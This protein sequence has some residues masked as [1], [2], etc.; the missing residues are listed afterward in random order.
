[1]TVQASDSGAP[2][3]PCYGAGPLLAPCRGLPELDVVAHSEV[4]RPQPGLEVPFREGTLN[5]YLGYKGTKSISVAGRHYVLGG[6]DLFITPPGVRHGTPALP[7]TRCAHYWL[8][9]RLDLRRPFLGD[10]ALEP[11]RRGLRSART[12]VVRQAPH[13]LTAV[14]AV[15]DLCSAPVAPLRDLQIRLQLALLLAQMLRRLTAS[16]PERPQP[17]VRAVLDHLARHIGED[18]AVPDMAD[19]AGVSASG[20]TAIFRAR[21][22]MAPGEY[23]A[24][25]KMAEARRLLL[26]T[27][28]QARQIG[29]M[30]GFRSERYF[31]AAFRRH[32]LM[33]PGRFRQRRGVG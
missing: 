7:M 6:G 18:I 31:S 21:F 3:H 24:R 4:Q 16:E 12:R 27:D 11:L 20:L 23:F 13:D 30:L 25:M 14:R 8:R 32:F 29:Q 17:A 15:Y 28:L 2:A 22:G 19:V 9:I 5:L 33:P 10:R 26:S 1:M